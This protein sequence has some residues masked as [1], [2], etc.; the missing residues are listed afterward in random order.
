MKAK[1]K[2]A[3][4]RVSRGEGECLEHTHGGGRALDDGGDH[5]AHSQT[6]QG[7][8]EL[9]HELGKGGR[10]GQGA[11][12]VA[13]QVH[14]EDED[15]EA[16]QDSADAALSVVLAG[17]GHDDAHHGE[18]EGEVLGFQHLHPYGVTLDA[19]QTQDPRGDG[20]A[21]VGAEDDVEG[22]GE[23]HDAGVDQADDHD[24]GGRRGLDGHGD[25]GAQGQA[26]EGVGGHL[27]QQKLQLAAGHLFQA[28]GHD[29]HAVEEE[30][31]TTDESEDREDIHGDA[32][33]LRRFY[34]LFT[35][36]LD[37]TSF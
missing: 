6:H 26:D 27:F 3:L 2:M 29:V 16:H 7:L 8:V 28:A 33:P 24:G 5:G 30:G 9:G 10:I 35:F 25:D 13:H 23:V 36:K 21:D 11:H 17:H 31:Q 19:G 1:W 20:G 14:A 32:T 37:L 18:D 12:G 15:G 34:T 4:V 22:L